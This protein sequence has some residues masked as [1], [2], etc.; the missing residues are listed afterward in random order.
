VVL[1]GFTRQEEALYAEYVGAAG[2][3][4]AAGTE[5]LAGI[6]LRRKDLQRLQPGQVISF[7]KTFSSWLARITY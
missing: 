5:P 2:D 4:E 6:V 1:Y 7:F 3:G